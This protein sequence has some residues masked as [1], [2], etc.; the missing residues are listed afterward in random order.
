MKKYRENE[1]VLKSYYDLEKILK[2]EKLISSFEYIKDRNQL[3]ELLLK[4]RKYNILKRILEFREDGINNIQNFLDNYL[5]LLNFE[6]NL[7]IEEK[8]EIY[9]DIDNKIGNIYV[10]KNSIFSKDI[11]L[12]VNKNRYIYAIG[13]LKYICDER[14]YEKYELIIKKD[15]NRIDLYYSNEELFFL[16]LEDKCDIKVYEIY[17]NQYISK[18]YHES[19]YGFIFKIEEFK[20]KKYVDTVD[21]IYINMKNNFFESIYL[22]EEFFVSIFT[23]NVYLYGIE[24]RDNYINS[25]FSLQESI[26]FNLKE[27]L[28]NFEDKIVVKNFFSKRFEINYKDIYFKYMD[29]YISKIEMEN[30]IK[31]KNY[32]PIIDEKYIFNFEKIVSKSYYLDFMYISQNYIDLNQK[33]SKELVLYLN[34]YSFSIFESICEIK[35]AKI[36]YN[37]YLKNILKLKTNS[38]NYEKIIELLSKYLKYNEERE[39]FIS[40]FSYEDD[41]LTSLKN[42]EYKLENVYLNDKEKNKYIY[43]AILVFNYYLKN[44]NKAFF[45]I[46]NMDTIINEKNILNLHIEEII[47][48]LSYESI[49]K[50]FEKY[51]FLDIL[52]TYNCVRLNGNILKTKAFFEVIKEYIAGNFINLKKSEDKDFLYKLNKIYELENEGKINFDYEFLDLNYRFVVYYYNHKEEKIKIIDSDN[53]LKGYIDKFESTNYLDIEFEI[54]NEFKDSEVITKRINIL[55]TFLEMDEE[56]IL[57]LTDNGINL[58]EINEI[59]NGILRVFFI[60]KDNKIKIYFIKRIFDQT[61]I[62]GIEKEENLTKNIILC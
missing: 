50:F 56:K 7:K 9:I 6:I 17:Y 19:I 55:D 30:K 25:N 3:I 45:K 33:Y 16:F 23:E 2:N 12:I 54:I 28:D 22:K 46:L 60:F 57:E 15:L 40:L 38:F 20:V 27:I 44:Q 13:Y 47:Q 36:M 43:N 21:L 39:N 4:Y 61:Y 26:F 29:Y 1:I 31:V 48:Y 8:I 62:K 24:A 35:D 41:F 10:T 14:E 18:L 32:I 53:I 49:K 51:N 42:N 52:K 5:I 37:V 59:V 58:S 11:V 34:D